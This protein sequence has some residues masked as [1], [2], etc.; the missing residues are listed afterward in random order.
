MAN[1]SLSTYLD[2]FHCTGKQA[3][4]PGQ[5]REIPRRGAALWSTTKLD[6]ERFLRTSS[7]LEAAAPANTTLQER[8]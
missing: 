3:L 6:A 1:D 5:T 4:E 7:I 8:V 2:S